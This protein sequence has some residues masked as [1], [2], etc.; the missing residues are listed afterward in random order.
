M[1]EIQRNIVRPI[2]ILGLLMLG[3]DVDSAVS[4][5]ILA[6]AAVC[7][8]HNRRNLRQM[9]DTD[10]AAPLYSYVQGR[11][12]DL[13]QVSILTCIGLVFGAMDII[14]FGL[15]SD[16]SETGIY[17]AGSR[18]GML[19]NI[20][21]LAGNAQMVRHI[22]RVAAQTDSDNQCLIAMKR[23]I[24]LVRIAASSM[25]LVLSL[26]LPL[27][28]WVVDL[29]ARELWPVFAVVGGSYW[30]QGMLG[31]VNVFLM[32]AHETNQLIRYHFWGLFAFVFVACVLYQLGSNLAIPVAV[33]VG[34]NT[35]KLLAW[36]RI[37]RS[38]KLWI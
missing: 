26:G 20:A 36:I 23:Q 25:L 27:Y 11:S 8:W 1:S 38:R 32:Q 4:I 30:L 22:A 24:K 12:R 19:V 31:P 35:V 15:L 34:A 33:A 37:G 16:P 5:G 3:L 13:K 28:A 9:P 21:L 2:L 17:G 14:L 18:F 7:L 29:P 10:E 6:A